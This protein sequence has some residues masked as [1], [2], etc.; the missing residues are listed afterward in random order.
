MQNN[1]CIEC[2]LHSPCLLYKDTFFGTLCETKYVFDKKK[3]LQY[4]KKKM[5][6]EKNI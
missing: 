2:W 6:N 3:D 4:W 5:N 1:S